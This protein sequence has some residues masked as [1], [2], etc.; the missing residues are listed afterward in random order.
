VTGEAAVVVAVVAVED[1]G[2][3]LGVVAA[4]AGAEAGVV[5]GE[6]LEVAAVVAVAE[7]EAVEVF[8]SAEE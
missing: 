8:R 5:A 3:A 6:A 1:Q 4:V 7:E 2:V